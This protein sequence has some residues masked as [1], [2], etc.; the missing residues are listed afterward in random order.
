MN[1]LACQ[2][3]GKKYKTK[4]LQQIRK[5]RLGEVRAFV[6]TIFYSFIILICIKQA[7]L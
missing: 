1:C 7:R 5:G 3:F 4:Q 2:P 6:L